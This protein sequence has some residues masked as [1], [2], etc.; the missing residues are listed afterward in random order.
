MD[1]PR[2]I[3]QAKAVEAP[4]GPVE[5]EDSDDDMEVGGFRH[6]NCFFW[7]GREGG[8]GLG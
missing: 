1:Q 5:L 6:L 3:F 8:G 7:G 2:A 4:S